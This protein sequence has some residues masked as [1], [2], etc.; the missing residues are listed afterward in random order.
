[1]AHR[2]AKRADSVPLAEGSLHLDFFTDQE[3]ANTAV[4]TVFAH[5][6]ATVYVCF[7]PRGIVENA[8]KK[9]FDQLR[10]GDTGPPERDTIVIRWI[11]DHM[12]R[13][14]AVRTFELADGRAVSS[15]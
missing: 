1:M 6:F 11:L 12:H 2:H 3:A 7:P 8:R 13:A 10:R 15:I 14:T 4:F 5:N 9:L